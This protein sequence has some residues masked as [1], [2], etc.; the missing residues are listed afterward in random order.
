MRVEQMGY[1]ALMAGLIG[2]L[3]KGTL[4]V[5]GPLSTVKDLATDTNVK[6]LHD[7]YLARMA[8]GVEPPIFT[9]T[10]GAPQNESART[11]FV[12]MAKE[13]RLPTT[14]ARAFVVGLYGRYITGA[15]PRSAYDPRGEAV[16]QA[17][18][19]EVAPTIIER[20]TKGGAGVVQAAQKRLTLIAG[21]AALLGLGLFMAYSR[22]R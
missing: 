5:L 16:T 6:R 17:A 22:K 10:S 8:R 4:H 15:V 18:R 21:G 13:L 9:R 1:P 11:I 7:A 2:E 12:P 3:R 19:A 20:I 14:L